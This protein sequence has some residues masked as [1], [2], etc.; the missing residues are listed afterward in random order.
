MSGLYPVILAGGSGTRLWPVSRKRFPK[1]F[2]R[3]MGE[4][5]LFQSS[6]RRLSGAGFEAPVVMTADDFRFIVRDQLAECAVPEASIV[7]EPEG[8]NTAPATL[9]AALL[10]A[11]KDPNALMLVAPSDHSIPDA[12]AFGSAI[13]AALPAARRGSLVTFGIKP[14]RAETGYGYL[15]LQEGSDPAAESLQKL[16]AFVEKPDAERAA[17]MVESGRFLWNAGVFLMSVEA[18]VE[19]FRAHAP[20]ILDAVTRSLDSA[21][22]DLGFTRLGERPWSSVEDI[23]IDRAI[24]EKASDLSVMPFGGAWSDVGSWTTVWQEAS[25]DEAGNALSPTATAMECRDSLLWSDGGTVRLVGIGLEGLIAVATRD[26]VL[27]APARESQKVKAAVERLRHEGVPEADAFPTDQR[28]WGS[29]ESL[30][31]G[32]RFQVKRIVVK[33]GGI[34]SLQSHMH[35]AEHWIVVAGTA[36]VTVGDEVRLISE[37][38]SIYVPLGEKHRLENPGKVPMVLIEVQTGTYLGEDDIVRYEDIY[39]RD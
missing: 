16:K 7:I 2:A 38:Q 17:R 18:L 5:S 29:F 37:N 30:A 13:R 23:S 15:E 4:E 35:R 9:A 14:T 12:E 11:R 33:P 28:P 27:V 19:A 36:K 6:A 3:L 21:R 22:S 8:R 39:A 32:D 10:I 20:G 34:L 26:A 24:M 25:R 1:Q 31:R